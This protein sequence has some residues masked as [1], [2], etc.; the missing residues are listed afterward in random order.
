MGKRGAQ[1]VGADLA[2]E[3]QKE[4]NGFFYLENTEQQMSSFIKNVIDQ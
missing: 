2:N 4:T 1:L 3:R